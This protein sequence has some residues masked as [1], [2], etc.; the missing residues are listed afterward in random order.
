MITV[1]AGVPADA[2]VTRFEDTLNLVLFHSVSSAT[3]LN[4]EMR[5]HGETKGLW[6]GQSGSSISGRE[7]ANIETGRHEA[8]DFQMAGHAAGA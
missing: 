3:C 2:L 4:T 5:K 6:I 8:R 7:A 1:L